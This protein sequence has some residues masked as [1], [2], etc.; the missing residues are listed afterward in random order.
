MGYGRWIVKEGLAARP[1]EEKTLEP[2]R[3]TGLFRPIPPGL[4]RRRAA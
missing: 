2:D 4:R 1:A 3:N